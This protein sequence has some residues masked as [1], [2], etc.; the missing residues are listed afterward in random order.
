[1][2]TYQCPVHGPIDAGDAFFL[3]ATEQQGA[4]DAG[5]KSIAMCPYEHPEGQ[6]W[7][8]VVWTS[9]LQ[10]VEAEDPSDT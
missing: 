8:C 9:T 10:P 3:P 1:M 6:N 4:P 7:L 2:V 5:T